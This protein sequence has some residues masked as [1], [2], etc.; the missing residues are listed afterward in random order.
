M[1]NLDSSQTDLRTDIHKVR[2]YV[3]FV[4]GRTIAS[5]T[6]SSTNQTDSSNYSQINVTS[7]TG[8]LDGTLYDATVYFYDGTS[9]ALKGVTRVSREG[10]PNGTR[11][12]IPEKST[13]SLNIVANDTFT[14]K[15][16]RRIATRL[17]SESVDFSPDNETWNDDTEDLPPIV[18]SGGGYAS[19]VDDGE[20]YATVDF[21]GSDS[22]ATDPDNSS[23]VTHSWDFGSDCTPT[24]STDANPTGVQIPVVS[25]GRWIEHVVT[26]ADSGATSRQYVPVYIHDD[27]YTPL[28]ATVTG[29]RSNSKDGWTFDFTSVGGDDVTL[30]TIPDGCAL[31]FW[32]DET[33][34][35]SVQ[36][37]GS[38]Y[39]QR[40]HIKFFGYLDT[41]NESITFGD[42]PVNFTTVSPLQRLAQITGFGLVILSVSTATTWQNMKGL[43][44][45]RAMQYVLRS[46]TTVLSVCDLLNDNV[47]DVAYPSFYIRKQNPYAQVSELADALDGRLTTTRRGSLHFNLL[48]PYIPPS[49][50]GSVVRT[51]TLTEDDITAIT[52]SRSHNPKME[53]VQINGFTTGTYSPVFALYPSSAPDG[54]VITSNVERLIV[55]SQDDL[56]ER[57]GRRGAWLERVYVDDTT[58]ERHKGVSGT[59]TLSGTYDVFDFTDA[60][61]KVD[62]DTTRRGIDLDD[63][64][65][66]V[67]GIEVAY[68]NGT[69]T[70]TLNYDT[71]TNAPP[72]QYYKPPPP[73][74]TLSGSTIETPADYGDFT[75]DVQTVT[76]P[77]PTG[78]GFVPIVTIPT[79]DGG[80]VSAWAIETT[81]RIYR[82]TNFDAV[83]P[84]WTYV[85]D[86]IASPYIDWENDP[87]KDGVGWGVRADRA[88]HRYEN[89]HSG[90][91]SVTNTYMLPRSFNY[92]S[93]VACPTVEDYVIAITEEGS[94]GVHI[95][96]TIDG[97]VNWS[98]VTLPDSYYGFSGAHPYFAPMGF[99]DNGGNFWFSYMPYDAQYWYLGTKGNVP[100]GA[101]YTSP[102]G[103]SNPVYESNNLYVEGTGSGSNTT[104]GVT[105]NIPAPETGT[106]TSLQVVGWVHATRAGGADITVDVD[107]SSLSGTH[108][109]VS[110]NDE[111]ALIT[112]SF[113]GSRTINTDLDLTL[114]ANN[115]TQ[116]DGSFAR[117]L[118]V[119]M[120]I[121]GTKYQFYRGT[122]G[123]VG[124]LT[125][126]EG[127][128]SYL[129]GLNA[130]VVKDGLIVFGGSASYGLASPSPAYL[131]VDR[132]T[133][134]NSTGGVVNSTQNFDIYRAYAGGTYVNITPV[135]NGIRGT[136]NGSASPNNRIC[137]TRETPNT[138]VIHDV[139]FIDGSDTTY[140]TLMSTNG[141]NSWTVVHETDTLDNTIYGGVCVGK[142][143]FYGWGGDGTLI[144]TP[145]GGNTVYDKKGDLP[146]ETIIG[147][148]MF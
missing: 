42:Y 45:F 121:S 44:V 50:R 91:V 16:E 28:S 39:A 38:S 3:S 67:T 134:R 133:D 141:G 114:T 74:T 71:C 97:G 37:F 127:L 2:G 137:T 130:P 111:L 66:F 92:V 68:N 60:I 4:S 51:L 126:A 49:D 26:D 119:Q 102:S 84:T 55:S 143:G 69:A 132:S 125:Q 88:I 72:A 87:F 54:G 13:A 106:L 117:L 31:L 100:T 43:T 76:P 108:N 95:Y 46:Y 73:Q 11:F 81:G 136:F 105:A 107:G 77:P 24:T 146:D 135:I 101:S 110:L 14:V 9:G 19:Y 61:I 148:G 36:S 142:Q 98:E 147:V 99:F 140:R 27:T 17:P 128:T 21:Y 5:G 83:S 115:V 41:D 1:P 90:T 23:G 10:V 20:A 89:L 124:K 52:V 18:V 22:Y 7:V 15:D 78:G 144:Y 118:Y 64:D 25:G 113:S 62:I 75:L 6:V 86:L 85:D 145:D 65:L 56:Q 30:T 129:S 53:I 112:W 122:I 57:G 47:T 103:G 79:P 33:I 29:M 94:G 131:V 116:G 63:Y 104:V 58:N 80:D 70:V 35:G 34:N 109:T 93:I 8:T 123:E 82:T 12:Y 139:R 96:K 32:V 40:S 59:I 48:P 120:N 138:V